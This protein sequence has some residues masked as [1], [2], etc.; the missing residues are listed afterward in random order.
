[1]AIVAAGALRLIGFACNVLAAQ[2]G[3]RDLRAL[4]ARSRSRSRLGIFAIARGAVIEPPAFLTQPLANAVR[5][6]LGAPCDR[7][8]LSAMVSRTLIRYFGMRFLGAVASVF[9]GIFVLVVLVDYVEFMRRA[10]DVPN[11][12]AWMVAKASFFRVPAA[13]RAAAAVL[14]AG[15]RDGLLPGAVA[16]QRAGHRALRRN[17][18]L[19]VR[20][21]R[22]DRAPSRIGL[23]ATAVYNPLSAAMREWSKRLEAE[24]FGDQ[25]ARCSRRP[26][27]FWV[28]QRS[29]GRPVR[30]STRPRARNRACGSTASACSPSTTAGQELERI[31]AKRA[32]LEPGPL[33]ARAG[34]CLRQRRAAA[35]PRNLSGQDQPDRRAGSGKL[36]DPGNGPVL[37]PSSVYRNRRALRARRRRL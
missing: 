15:R 23:L 25:Q 35:R 31:E 10:A 34:A 17:V 3:G 12:S 37:G 4:C 7:R 1:M 30:S 14:G 16:A 6:P 33:A 5:A 13:H 20:G 24:I 21:A 19:A 29:V 22:A 32:M 8:E 18:G 36:F 2:I 9:F 11:V 26:A 28:R 27:G